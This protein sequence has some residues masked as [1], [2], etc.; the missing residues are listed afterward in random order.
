VGPSIDLRVLDMGTYFATINDRWDLL[1]SSRPIRVHKFQLSPFSSPF[2]TRLS[3]M[4]KVGKNHGQSARASRQKWDASGKFTRGSGVEVAPD[5]SVGR[6]IPSAIERTLRAIAWWEM[7]SGSS[8]VAKKT[9]AT[10]T[11]SSSLSPEHNVSTIFLHQ[12]PSLIRVPLSSP[13]RLGFRIRVLS[14]WGSRHRRK[15]RQRRR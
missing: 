15:R 5:A 3:K 6:E 9:M 11:A 14:R 12:C 10:T 2:H 7:R 1:V 13:V 4:R 8:V